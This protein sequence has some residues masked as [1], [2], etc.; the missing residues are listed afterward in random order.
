[1][2]GSGE[3]SWR[4]SSTGKLEPMSETPNAGSRKSSLA[5]LRESMSGPGWIESKVETGAPS[6]VKP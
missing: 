3:P 4:R 2:I 5:K 1:M 6:H